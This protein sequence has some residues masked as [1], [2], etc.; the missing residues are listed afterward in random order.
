MEKLLYPLATEKAIRLIES[1]NVIT[2]IVNEKSTK[3]GV[4]KE[5]EEK[6]KSKVQAIRMVRTTKGTKKAY[7]KLSKEQPAIDV[8][9]QLGLM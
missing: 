6:F 9:T 3:T 2:F 7:I 8:A 1:D 4:Q 5:F